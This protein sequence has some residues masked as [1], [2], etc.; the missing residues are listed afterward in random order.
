MAWQMTLREWL[1]RTAEIRK[2][3]MYGSGRSGLGV[4]I[5]EELAAKYPLGEVREGGA[6]KTDRALDGTVV[7]P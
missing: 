2:G 1:R 3:Y 7:K 5:N 4:D 6:Y